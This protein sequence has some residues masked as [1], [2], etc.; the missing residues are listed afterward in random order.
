MLEPSPKKSADKLSV[1][2]A[3]R[4]G[5]N[6]K[7]KPSSKNLLTKKNLIKTQT[8][9]VYDLGLDNIEIEKMHQVYYGK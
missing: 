1:N 7:V 4:H 5:S 3:S 9:V 8:N 6:Q 2:K